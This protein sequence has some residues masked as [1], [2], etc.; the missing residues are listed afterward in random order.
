MNLISPAA[1]VLLTV[2]PIVI[3]VFAS[4][5][6][7]FAILW[8]HHE[9]KL[10]IIKEVYKPKV[11]NFKAF[12]LLTGLCLTGIG[13]VLSFVFIIVNG[14][15]ISVLVG[16]IPFILGIML[17]TFYKVNPDFNN[18]PKDYENSNC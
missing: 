8:K 13:F 15:T 9:N 3:A 11:F 6:I 14:F 16:L 5:L 18:S 1:Q 10:M 7:F 12:S 17:L 4:I 2:F